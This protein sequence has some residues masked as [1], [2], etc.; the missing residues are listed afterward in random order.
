MGEPLLSEPPTCHPAIQTA[1]CWL[2]SGS[3]IHFRAWHLPELY[4]SGCKVRLG[5]GVV[6]SDL[7]FKSQREME[8]TSR[9]LLLQTTVS[10]PHAVVVQV[11]LSLASASCFCARLSARACAPLP[12][13]DFSCFS[14]AR[15]PALY[16]S[17]SESILEVGALRQ[18]CLE[19]RI[20]F[21]F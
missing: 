19:L 21:T 11:R 14:F 4:P 5:W 16:F 15:P 2:D 3:E 20:L 13:H 10:P 18:L 1:G 6:T 9:V 7:H 12:A 8:F 17:F